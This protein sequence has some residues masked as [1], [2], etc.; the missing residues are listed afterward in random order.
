MAATPEAQPCLILSQNLELLGQGKIKMKCLY[1][2]TLIPVLFA[3]S[4]IAH[5]VPVNIGAYTFDDSAFVSSFTVGGSS[6]FYN[7]DTFIS[8]STTPVTPSDEIVG[9]DPTTF[10]VNGNYT[11]TVNAQFGS[12]LYNGD[13][14]DLAFFFVGDPNTINLSLSGITNTYNSSIQIEPD[15]GRQ[16]VIS[17]DALG[18]SCTN[19][20]PCPLSAVM[21]DLDDFNWDSAMAMDNL[22]IGFGGFGEAGT[23]NQAYLSM[24]AGFHTSPTAVPLPAPLLLLLSGLTAL[25]LISRR[26]SS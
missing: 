15:T 19:N 12:S 16:Y 4:N 8:G 21:V 20:T 13:G 3:L 25:G 26:K 22:E 2:Y 11:S 24:V 7:Q 1:T 9:Y 5:A 18:F 14:A 23:S 10:L 17:P 6:V